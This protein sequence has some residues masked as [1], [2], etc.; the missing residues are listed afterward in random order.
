MIHNYLQK[1][2]LIDI[3]FLNKK[4]KVDVDDCYLVVRVIY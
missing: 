2:L 4:I 3:F 1:Y